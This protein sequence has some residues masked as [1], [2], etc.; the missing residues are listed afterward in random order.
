MTTQ[1]VEFPGVGRGLV[2]ACCPYLA[3]P[4]ISA[5][6]RVFSA[7]NVSSLAIEPSS[8]LRDMARTLQTCRKSTSGAT[9]PPEATETKSVRNPS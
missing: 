4:A 9:P 2:G 1:G 6:R 8:Y 3:T 7:P 5:T